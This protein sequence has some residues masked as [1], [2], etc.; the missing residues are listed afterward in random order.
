M[1]SSLVYMC[2]DYVLDEK[3]SFVLDVAT[4]EDERDQ[5]FQGLWTTVVN[6]ISTHVL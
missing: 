3:E 4:F 5:L 2:T 6:S 1:G